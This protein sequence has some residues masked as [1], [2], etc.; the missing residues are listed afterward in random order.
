[1][2]YKKC[3]RNCEHAYLSSCKGCNAFGNDKW[4]NFELRKEL[5][6]IENGTLVRLPC[7]VGDKIYTVAL[8]TTYNEWGIVEN[9]VSKDS[10]YLDCVDFDKGLAF[11]TRA[12]AE[13]KLKELRGE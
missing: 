1:M 11:F 12:E 8:H 3:C 5:S 6:E 10:L 4:Q 13:A 2:K 9:V 7:K